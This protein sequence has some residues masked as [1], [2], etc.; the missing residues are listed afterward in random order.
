MHSSVGLLLHDSCRMPE[1]FFY[2]PGYRQARS[3]YWVH[4]RHCLPT[5]KHS[6][7]APSTGSSFNT[8]GFTTHPVMSVEKSPG[9]LPENLR[10]RLDLTISE[11]LS[12]RN[13]WMQ[14]K[15]ELIQQGGGANRDL[16][17]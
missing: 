8:G 11:D 10:L 16:G 15:N 5:L 17:W 13:F 14:H 12:H 9:Y 1:G 4:G 7:P 6:P 2:S 3:R